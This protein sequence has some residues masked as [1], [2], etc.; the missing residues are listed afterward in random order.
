MN[1]IVN[2]CLQRWIISHP[3]V[4]QSPIANYYITVKFDDGN[5][6][7]NTEL[8]QKVLIHVSVCEQH[9]NMFKKDA[10]GFSM[11]YDEKGNLFISYST[12]QLLFSPQL[13]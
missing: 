1:D 4:I 7:V 5:G 8:F 10:T 2:S 12:L 9:I 3:H 6:G 11:A 13:Q